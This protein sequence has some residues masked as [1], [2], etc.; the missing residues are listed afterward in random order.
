MTRPSLALAPWLLLLALSGAPLLAEPRLEKVPSSAVYPDFWHTPLGIH[1]G[2][3]ALLKLLTSDQARFDDPLG[4]ACTRM[5]EYGEQSPQI[6]AFGVNSN[7]GQIVYNPSMKSLA[8]FGQQ[9]WGEGRFYKPVGVACR[10]DGRVVVADTGNQ[11]LVLLRFHDGKLYWVNTL[12]QRGHGP[13]Q[14]VD[15]RWV[16]LD[17]Q[18]RIYVS[19]TGNNRIQVLDAQ[20]QF[21]YSFGDNPNA[22]NSLDEPQAIAVVDPGEPYSPEPLG[23]IYVVDQ[24]HGRVQ[25]FSLDGRFLG[26]T[27]AEDLGR[28]TVYFEGIALD[29]FNNLWVADRSSDQL[30]KYDQHLQ[31]VDSWG[32]PGEGDGKLSSPRGVAIY[33]HYGQLLVLEAESAQYLWIGTDIK[34]VRFSRVESRQKGPELRIDYRVTDRAWVDTWVEDL[35]QNKLVQLQTHKLQKEGAQTI[36]W[37]GDISGGYRIAPGTYF[38][39]FQA[40]ATYSSATYV[41]REMRKRFVVK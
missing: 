34:E 33:R 37:N 24:H 15:P 4:L 14:F 26:Q 32:K 30:H 2:S 41:K 27:T 31:W 17:S 29:Y 1:R 40:E 21:L 36:F 23:A 39:V 5:D 7:A 8:V 11:R 10:P 13:G 22:N 25:K 3:P 12:G 35:E 38:L 16:A 18:G 9:G 20:G 6:T 19:D 28:P